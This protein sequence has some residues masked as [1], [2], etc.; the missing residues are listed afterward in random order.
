M[1][2]ESILIIGAGASGLMAANLLAGQMEVMILEAKAETGGRIKSLTRDGKTIE[3]SAEFIHGKLPLTLGLL[4]DAGIETVPVKGKMYHFREG[5]FVNENKMAA[6]WDKLLD[7]IKEAPV[8]MTLETFLETYYSAQVHGALRKEV[9]GY[10]EGFDLADITKASIKSL[11]AEWNAEDGAN[12]RI[13]SGYG[14]LIQHLEQQAIQSGVKIMTGKTVRQIDWQPNDVT[15]YTT[16][17]E[18][19][20]ASRLLVTIPVSVLAKINSPGSINFTP[21]IDS[22]QKAAGQIGY[23]SVIKVILEFNHRF[24][25]A[26]AG[27]IISDEFF[28]TWWTQLPDTSAILTGWLGGP[29]AEKLSSETDELILYKALQ[30]LAAIFS[31]SVIQIQDMLSDSHIFNWQNDPFALGGYSY[32]TIQSPG[33][34]TL[35][36]TPLDKTLFFAG[37]ALYIGEHNATVEA[38]LQSAATTAKI[39]LSDLIA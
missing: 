18:Q 30:S 12:F 14:S 20:K 23:G 19:F 11:Y 36:S 9:A 6:G 32:D 5:E 17:G 31:M 8:D 26:D 2:K 35:L 4:A 21:E 15:L 10:A 25:P 24:W 28:K 22:Y 33:A 38:A 29:S 7:D 34:K 3:T 27:F 13:P 16:K 39:I 37:E 1:K